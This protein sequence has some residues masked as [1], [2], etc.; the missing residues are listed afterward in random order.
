MK[1]SDVEKILCAK[2][3][4]FD[5]DGTLVDSMFVWESVD[6]KYLKRMGIQVEEDLAK[7]LFTMSMAEA[8]EY[9]RVTYQIPKTRE[10]IAQEIVKM[11]E[12]EYFYHISE[13]E[14]IEQLLAE[15]EQRKIPMVIATSCERVLAEACLKRLGLL[16]YF[17]KIFTSTEVGTGKESPRIYEE[18]ARYLQIKPED[19]YV[20]EDAVHA[21][22]TAKKAGFMVVGIYDRHS[23]LHQT[24][25]KAVADIYLHSYL[26]K[27]EIRLNKYI[28]DAGVCS[29]RQADRLIEEGRVTVDEKIAC[30]GSKVCGE[31]EVCVD[32]ALVKKEEEFILLAYHKPRGIEC[33]ANPEIEGNVIQA[34]DYPKKVFYVGRL[35]KDSEGLLLFTNQGTLA[36]QIA[37]ATNGHEKEYEVMINR[38]VDDAFL[39]KMSGGVHI[40]KVEKVHGEERV[41]FDTVTRKCRV[42][43]KGEKTFRIV[44]TQGLNRQIRRMCQ[45]CQARVVSLKRVRVMNILLG[46]LKPG[47]YREVTEQEREQ[48]LKMVQ[49]SSQGQAYEDKNIV[50]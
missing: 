17:S 6:E 46:D 8:T 25:L 31:E 13:K 41:I 33:T 10:E 44:I 22:E 48:L 7:R 23:R 28:S 34:L 32:G 26:E 45:A 3:M 18:A 11:V 29:R 16:R 14:G 47:A 1:Q 12:E 30:M 38:N 43:K 2:G 24:D 5:M 15:I 40:S 9:L 50:D 35:D 27:P 39:K 37:K 21:A 19:I 4:I 20:F 42:E 49:E 36:N